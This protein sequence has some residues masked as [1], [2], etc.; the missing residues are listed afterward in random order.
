M[1]P[2]SNCYW[3]FCVVPVVVVLLQSSFLP[4]QV[5]GQLSEKSLEHLAQKL[6]SEL[7]RITKTASGHAQLEQGFRKMGVT[8]EKME[9]LAVMQDVANNVSLMM[10]NKVGAVKRLVENA[11]EMTKSAVW[12]PKINLTYYNA[13]M[14]DSNQTGFASMEFIKDARFNNEEVN[15]TFS[16]VHVPTNIFNRSPIVLN[17]IQ[18]SSQLD[19]IFRRNLEDD[20]SLK[21]QYFGSADGFLR[22]YPGIKWTNPET[23]R[24]DMYDCRLTNWYIRASSSPKDM[25]ILVDISGSMTGIREEIARTTVKEIMNTLHEDDFFNIIKFKEEAQF[26]DTCAQGTL[27]QASEMTKRRYADLLSTL[28]TENIANYTEAF[29]MAFQTLS[30]SHECNAAECN[31]AIMVVSD[32]VPETF[33]EIFSAL[34][35][36]KRVRIFTYVI[37]REVT[38][39]DEMK[40]IACQN[41]GYVT[42]VSTMAD[43]RNH[44]ETCISVFSRPLGIS[45]ELNENTEDVLSW[46]THVTRVWSS[47]GM[48]MTVAQ[49]V[50]NR[51][52]IASKKGSLIG[53][54]GI[55]VPIVD[56]KRQMK[57]Q[58]WTVGSYIFATNHNG[59]CIFHPYWR[60]MTKKSTL[61]RHS[62]NEVDLGQVEFPIDVDLNET[63]EGEFD[64]PL[65]RHMIDQETGQ[66][67]MKVM[68]QLDER[69]RVYERDYIYY[70]AGVAS[71]QLS[72]ALALPV[73]AGRPNS[74]LLRPKGSLRP[75]EFDGGAVLADNNTQLRLHPDWF[76][77]NASLSSSQELLF[78]LY[79]DLKALHA[80][81]DSDEPD[82]IQCETP[83]TEHLLFDLKASQ[84]AV[85]SWPT[86]TDLHRK[87]SIETAFLITRAGATRWRDFPYE[88]A[89]QSEAQSLRMIK[90][91]RS[92]DENDISDP[93]RADPEATAESKTEGG[94][95]EE[96]TEKVDEIT[97][98]PAGA[99]PENTTVDIRHFLDQYNHAV[100]ESFYERTVSN[101]NEMTV[102]IPLSQG[103]SFGE[104]ASF[105]ASVPVFVGEG[106]QTASAAITGILMRVKRLRELLL[107][108]SAETCGGS[109]TCMSCHSPSVS[110][111]LVDESGYVV[112]STTSGE[113][114]GKFFGLLHGEVMEALIEEKIF[115][116]YKLHDYQGLCQAV[117]KARSKSAGLGLRTWWSYLLGGVRLLA[118]QF[119]AIISTIYWPIVGAES[120]YYNYEGSSLDVIYNDNTS[121]P[122]VST[123]APTKPPFLCDMKYELYHSKWTQLRSQLTVECR[124]NCTKSVGVYKVSTTNMLLIAMDK[125][126]ACPC[127]D[128]PL[129][130][131]PEEIVLDS[132]KL[133]DKYTAVPY[134]R[135]PTDCFPYH[136]DEDSSD[137]GAG[138]ASLIASSILLFFAVAVTLIGPFL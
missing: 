96:G 33:E 2:A 6:G 14:M 102:T 31:K 30:S 90:V 121:H 50:F 40:T 47:I 42:H 24:P 104:L 46:T 1:A 12:I 136:P 71:T 25:V 61:P 45:L 57:P 119:L 15:L 112:V 51:S 115:R 26:L 137:C 48:V 53:V 3:R 59:H 138:S 68:R 66:L 106:Q 41:R 123:E 13:K 127:S 72:I 63:S 116:R 67:T 84:P 99:A 17:G 60:L 27:V 16:S 82:Y 111:F 58:E 9:P 23:D 130:T 35:P 18:W 98:P 135:R 32:G 110:C 101:D 22:L 28:E 80:P 78:H 65:R 70:Y 109:A 113:Y 85:D 92:L 55:D 125:L 124:A 117:K 86:Q 54:V 76:Y 62:Y 8:V 20:P 44:V 108:I 74:E 56:I 100:D 95:D 77:C 94:E 87:Y 79:P 83:L 91:R 49:P 43:V 131:A 29:T 81:A 11:E 69:K 21:S 89:E 114:R 126:K 93:D 10:A 39:Y 75:A 73:N 134:R 133:C 107:D 118:T 4:S 88:E 128:S 132:D 19:V 7:F 122:T 97:E 36:E 37:G 120:E 103:P 38:V 5:C 129:T 34:N 52:S 105:M 64:L